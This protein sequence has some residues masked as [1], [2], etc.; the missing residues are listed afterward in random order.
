MKEFTGIS[1][2]R[3]TRDL[4]RWIARTERRTMAECL[5]LMIERR[6]RELRSPKST[7]AK[8]SSSVEGANSV[9]DGAAGPGESAIVGLDAAK[10]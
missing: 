2:R 8:M 10:A 3:S 1:I 7:E 9:G 6:F 4:L 5:S